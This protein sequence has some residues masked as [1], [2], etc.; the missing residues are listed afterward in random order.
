M[1]PENQ[2]VNEEVMQNV[3]WVVFKQVSK[4]SITEKAQ[5]IFAQSGGSSV[6]ILIN[7]E[8]RLHT[9]MRCCMNSVDIMF[10]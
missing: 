6:C 8:R 3:V 2:P 7:A 5:K 10:L 4:L 9:T 1:V